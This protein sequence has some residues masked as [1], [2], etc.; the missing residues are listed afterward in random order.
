MKSWQITHHDLTFPRKFINLH[1]IVILISSEIM[2]SIFSEHYDTENFPGIRH[3][4]SMLKEEKP[5]C[6]VTVQ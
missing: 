4:I 6:I 2:E 1:P 5:F 3:L